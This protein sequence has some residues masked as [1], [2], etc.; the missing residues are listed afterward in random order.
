MS[1]QHQI[2]VRTTWKEDVH[3]TSGS[4]GDDMSTQ[5]QVLAGTTWKE[6]VHTTSGSCEDDMEGGC[7]HNIRFL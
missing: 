7:P 4:C 5:H 3:T 2:L 6:D 1:T